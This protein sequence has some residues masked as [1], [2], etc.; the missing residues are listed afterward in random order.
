MTLT[1]QVNAVING[2]C[3]E[4][5]KLNGDHMDKLQHKIKWQQRFL[6]MVVHDMRNPAESIH[7]GL[8]LVQ[9]QINDAISSQITEVTALIEK[10]LFLRFQMKQSKEILFRVN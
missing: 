7:M 4:I 6:S 10:M 1:S 3:N 9:N 5:G 8:K 2:F